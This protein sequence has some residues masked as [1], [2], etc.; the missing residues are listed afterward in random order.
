MRGR[1]G[2]ERGREMDRED[3]EPRRGLHIYA[4]IFRG[5]RGFLLW[6]GRRGGNRRAERRQQEG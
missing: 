3:G 6:T 1:S 5:M 4:S 2:R